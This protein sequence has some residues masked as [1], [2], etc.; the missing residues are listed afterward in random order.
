MQNYHFNAHQV[1]KTDYILLA[2]NG[3]IQAINAGSP[4]VDINLHTVQKLDGGKV[5]WLKKRNH[6]HYKGVSKQVYSM[7]CYSVP[8]QTQRYVSQ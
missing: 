2:T 5:K 1:S 4:S 3:D 6:A 7:L 8:R